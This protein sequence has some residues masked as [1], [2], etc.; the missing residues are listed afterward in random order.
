MARKKVRRPV[1]IKVVDEEYVLRCKSGSRGIFREEVYQ[2]ASG[3]VVK[4]NL[5]FIHPSL[6]PKDNG[7]VLGYDNAHGFDERHW[8]G[9]SQRVKFHDYKSTFDRFIAELE[10]LKETL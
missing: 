1:V 7:R 9:E 8:M 10:T 5:A 2:D 4:Y 6:C 3:R